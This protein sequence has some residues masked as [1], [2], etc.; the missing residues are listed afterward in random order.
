MNFY[1]MECDDYEILWQSNFSK[2]NAENLETEGVLQVQ[3]MPFVFVIDTHPVIAFLRANAVILSINVD[4]VPP[5]ACGD[6]H[7]ISHQAL[8]LICETIRT[9]ILA[10]HESTCEKLNDDVIGCDVGARPS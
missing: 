3:N 10:R 9:R 4:D 2:W 6:Y 5:D 1:D 8:A 7:K